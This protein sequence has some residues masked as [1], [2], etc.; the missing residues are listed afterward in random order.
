MAPVPVANF[1]INAVDP[2]Q[3]RPGEL[4]RGAVHRL[5]LA[6][7]PEE[8]PVLVVRG[9]EAG[10]TL[11]V[12]AG[13]H[14]DEYEGV[15][16]ILETV[17]LL[18]PVIMRGDLLAVP[19]A[20]PAAFRAS[21]RTSPVDGLNLARVF[22][23]NASGKPTEVLAAALA[24]LVIGRGD[25]YLDL[26]SGGRAYGM[27]S[28]AGYDLND[29]RSIA[30]ARIFGA[31][32]IWGH[33]NIPAG[34]TISYAQAQNIPWIYTEARGAQRID[35]EDLRMMQQGILNLLCHLEILPG[36]PVVRPIRCRLRGDGDT[37]RGIAAS[38]SGFLL[39]RVHLLEEV[40]EGQ[41]LGVLVNMLGEPLEEYRAPRA[42]A[43]ALIHEF[44]I[45]QPG[46][47]LYLIAD[48]ER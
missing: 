32:T 33:A 30:A 25:F 17:A 8:I 35:R 43:A 45:V 9:A 40:S 46:D 23:G 21:Q 11:A 31:E 37:D 10:K 1:E 14:G 42:G 2:A 16:G 4:A 41:I 18:D 47:S 22:P 7:G 26:H 13:I 38:E 34:R 12:T 20:H 39:N 3:F 44:P 27:P 29:E 15:R 48:R 28:M 36:Q 19:V 5:R 24:E 6:A